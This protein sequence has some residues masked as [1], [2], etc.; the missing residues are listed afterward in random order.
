MLAKARLTGRA[1]PAEVRDDRIRFAAEMRKFFDDFKPLTYHI[2]PT[3]EYV[4]CRLRPPTEEFVKAMQ[5]GVR[6]LEEK[7]FKAIRLAN[8]T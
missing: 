5:G 2:C 7:E 3:G 1:I 6:I 8:F 4:P